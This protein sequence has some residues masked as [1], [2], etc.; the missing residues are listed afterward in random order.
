ME[1][2]LSRTTLIEDIRQ[3]TNIIETA[4]PDPYFKGGGRI[5]YH[6]RLQKLIRGIPPEGMTAKDFS[7]YLMP[8]LASIKDGHTTFLDESTLL[9]DEHPGGI[10][11]IFG[12]IE[13]R[14]YVR[15]VV[16]IAH[17]ELIGSLLVSVAGIGVDELLERVEYYFGCENRYQ[18]LG[19]LGNKPALLFY[20]ETLNLL[21]PEWQA[22]HPSSEITVVLQH[23]NGDEQPH[24]FDTAASN[25]PAQIISEHPSHLPPLSDPS[26]PYFFFQFVDET[27]HSPGEI[28]VLRIANMTTFREMYEYFRANAMD[29]FEAWGRRVYQRF[30]PGTDVPDDYEKVMAGIPAASTVFRDLFTAMKNAQTRYLIVD[31]RDNQGGNSLM[32]QILTYYLVGFERTVTLLKTN[33]TV[34]K[35]SE[36]LASFSE[37]SLD[38]AQ[39]PYFP[40]VPLKIT[41]YDFSLDPDFSGEQYEGSLRADLEGNFTQMPS[42]YPEFQ[43]REH[44]ALY[45]PERIFIL[46]S[47]LTFSTGFNLMVDLYQLDGEIVGIPSGQAGNSCGDVRSFELANSKFKGNVSTKSFIAFPDDPEAGELLMPQHPLTYEQFKAY[48]FDEN[49]TFRYALSLIAG[50]YDY[51]SS[52]SGK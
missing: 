52:G 11:L 29:R 49:T 25:G 4:H 22:A 17:Q 19:K 5:A 37:Q 38:P 10:P 24:V 14:L 39:I 3:L 15:A 27:G 8:F 31:L 44:E 40:Q 41:D 13:G 12:S 26:N 18:A 20:Q 21:I 42:F 51:Q 48:D 1:A 32:N 33:G 45:F 34:R 43:S 47:E 16:H 50:S 23:P 9:D 46:S 35:M 7:F 30:H 28:A 6:R 2:R 36:F